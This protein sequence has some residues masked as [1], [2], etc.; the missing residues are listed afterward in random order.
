MESRKD[1]SVPLFIRSQEQYDSQSVEQLELLAN[2]KFHNLTIHHTNSTQ[3]NNKLPPPFA[4][5]L[6]KQ[7]QDSS[8][9]AVFPNN[10]MGLD[11]NEVVLTNLNANTPKPVV[12]QN[13]EEYSRENDGF[14]FSSRH[15]L[16]DN[17]AIGWSYISLIISI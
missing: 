4:R 7:L 15:L 8:N 1:L 2:G 16:D 6:E 13:H 5:L 3:P 14:E 11:I 12:I 17:S 10:I 9:T